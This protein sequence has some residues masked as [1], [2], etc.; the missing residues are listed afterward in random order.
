MPKVPKSTRTL[1]M[2]VS[3]H[4]PPSQ[5]SLC[6]CIRDFT[7]MILGLTKNNNN[8][9]LPP[10][11]DE[12]DT[13]TLLNITDVD[14]DSLVVEERNIATEEA[15][16]TKRIPLKYKSLCLSEMA[17]HN[18]QHPTFQWD[19]KGQTRW[20]G[21][22]IDILV[23]RWLYAKNKEA[24]QEYPL[25]SDFC[26]KTI[27]SAIVEGKKHLMLFQNRLHMAKKLLGCETASQIIP[28][29]NCI[30][31]TEEDEDGNLLCIESNWRHN[32]YS[33][34]L[35]LLDTNTICSIRDRKRNNAANRCLES[36]RIIARNDSD[37]T[38][39][40]GLP[41]NCYSEEFLNGLNAT[42][43]LPLSIQKPCV[44]LDQH[45]FS[46]TPR[47]ILAEANVHP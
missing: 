45:I 16:I 1:N 13:A 40:P 20:D 15:S 30:S 23:K 33:L 11:S 34:L 39:C 22:V 31:D 12:V 35:H 42:H 5:D 37:Q 43:K 17:Q 19:V 7:K 14:I 36:H 28:H 29:M 27:V 26:T 3:S 9:P 18:I 4:I 2:L 8:L 41:S 32:R 44:Q 25:Q 24:F 6:I 10:S 38:A 47:H 46:I 21:L